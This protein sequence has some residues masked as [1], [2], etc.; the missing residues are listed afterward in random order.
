MPGQAPRQEDRQ[1]RERRAGHDPDKLVKHFSSEV[2][3][4]PAA[5]RARAVM[6][7]VASENGPDHERSIYLCR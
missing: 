4:G 1:K 3:P 7:N 2:G 6:V 5:V